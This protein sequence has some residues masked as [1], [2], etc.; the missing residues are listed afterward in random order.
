MKLTGTEKQ[1][2]WAED[3]R[4][5]YQMMMAKLDEAEKIMRDTTMT[6]EKVVDPIFGQEHTVKYYASKMTD[7][8]IAWIPQNC[9]FSPEPEKMVGHAKDISWVGE[10]E[11]QY[12][13]PNAGRFAQAD[14]YKETRENIEKALNTESSSKFWIENR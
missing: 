9:P 7:D 6:E 1:V 10:R 4:K 2:A 11:K 14:Y 3:I 8:L 13:G 12:E 5:K